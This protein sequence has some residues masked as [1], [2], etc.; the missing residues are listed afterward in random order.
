MVAQLLK[1]QESRAFTDEEKPV[2]EWAL[3]LLW[4]DNHENAAGEIPAQMY[5]S[6]MF[7]PGIRKEL[8]SMIMILKENNCVFIH[9]AS[10]IT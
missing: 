2:I 8:P 3:E 6:E 4:K 10:F 1:V 7:S 5:F 9:G